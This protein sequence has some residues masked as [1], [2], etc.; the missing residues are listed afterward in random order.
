MDRVVLLGLLALP[1]LVIL[2]VA[3][4]EQRLPP[5]AAVVWVDSPDGYR[6]RSPLQG[7]WR[8]PGKTSSPY[9]AIKTTQEQGS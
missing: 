2:H 3:L 5:G 9:F 8:V 1:V 4:F 6:D 7:H